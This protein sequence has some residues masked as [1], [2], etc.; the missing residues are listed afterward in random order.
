MSQSS[1]LK[2]LKKVLRKIKIYWKKRAAPARNSHS[3]KFNITVLSKYRDNINECNIVL[4]FCASEKKQM[5]IISD[6]VHTEHCKLLTNKKHKKVHKEVPK[7]FYQAK[8]KRLRV[9]F[10]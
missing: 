10:L 5:E 8:R 7:R 6:A 2:L 4:E 3:I 9:S 1:L